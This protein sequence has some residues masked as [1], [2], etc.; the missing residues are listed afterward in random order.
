VTL[1]LGVLNHMPARHANGRD[2]ICCDSVGCSS[3]YAGLVVNDLT[4]RANLA[5]CSASSRLTVRSLSDLDF[6]HDVDIPEP[7][8]PESLR[9]V[10]RALDCVDVFA[11]DRRPNQPRRLDGVAFSEASLFMTASLETSCTT[12]RF[13]PASR[14]SFRTARPCIERP[15]IEQRCFQRPYCQRAY[16]HRPCLHRPC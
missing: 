13:L 12:A 5:F 3:I 14:P 4:S 7:I 2:S 16:L 9:E 6:P 11:N 8:R 1:S 15:H 10:D